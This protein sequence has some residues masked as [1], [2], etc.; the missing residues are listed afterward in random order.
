MTAIGRHAATRTSGFAGRRV[1]ILIELLR[2]FGMAWFDDMELYDEEAMDDIFAQATYDRLERKDRSDVDLF[3]DVADFCSLGIDGG[4]DRHP[5]SGDASRLDTVRT[6]LVDR[7][8]ACVPFLDG[9]DPEESVRGFD[10]ESLLSA[11]QAYYE[12]PDGLPVD[13]FVEASFRQDG[14]VTQ[15]N[16]GVLRDKIRW[17]DEQPDGQAV[18]DRVAYPEGTEWYDALLP[19]EQLARESFGRTFARIVEQVR[20]GSFDTGILGGVDVTREAESDAAGKDLEACHA[21]EV[22]S[23][24]AAV[25]VPG[26]SVEE[27]VS[28]LFE[29]LQEIRSVD[30]SVEL[31][32]SEYE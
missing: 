10:P 3:G 31:G 29:E 23:P 24:S 27:E 4:F 20:T 16:Y 26:L 8:K 14:Y 18:L 30:D 19:Q 9:F 32:D 6:N 7:L 13:R 12:A 21:L 1:A 25:P 2:G 28:Q 17:T 22:E 15:L 11:V 5:P